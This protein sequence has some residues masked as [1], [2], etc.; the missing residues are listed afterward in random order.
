LI[1]NKQ[2]CIPA[3]SLSCMVSITLSTGVFIFSAAIKLTWSFLLWWTSWSFW[4]FLNA[5]SNDFEKETPHNNLRKEKKTWQTNVQEYFERIYWTKYRGK[6]KSNNNS[7]TSD[8][9]DGHP[10]QQSSHFF[11]I[12][13]QNHNHTHY[14]FFHYP[15]TILHYPTPNKIILVHTPELLVTTITLFLF[16][17]TFFFRF[18]CFCSRKIARKEKYL[19]IKWVMGAFWLRPTA[20]KNQ[21]L[22]CCHRHYNHKLSKT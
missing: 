6:K 21:L 17:V 14:S 3:S 12:N 5:L 20:K 2:L 22:A 13:H 19:W 16:T 9:R 18:F 8:H 10:Y 1:D 15:H 11:I 4:M 7:K